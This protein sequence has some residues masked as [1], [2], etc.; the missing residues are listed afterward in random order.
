MTPTPTT[1]RNSK[2][3]KDANSPLVEYVK[4]S[5]FYTKMTN[6]VITAIT[7]HY[8]AGV[9]TV[10]GLG[11]TFQTRGGAANYGIGSDGRIGL[12]VDES[13]RA[14]TSGN[15]QNDQKAVTIEVSNSDTGGDWPVSDLV[16][17]KLVDLCEDVCRRN[18]IPYLNFT[19][20]TDGNMTMHAWFQSTGCP[21][22]YLGSKFPYIA[23]E[24]NRRLGS[25]FRSPDKPNKYDLG[26]VVQ[27]KDGAKY[28][29]GKQAPDWLKGKMLYIRE[30]YGKY[31]DISIYSGE[32]QPI[33]GR[34][35]EKYIV[36]L[37][38]PEEPEEKPVQKEAGNVIQLTEDAVYTTGKTIPAWV[39]N[40][41]LYLREWVNDNV[42]AF[43]I[44]QTGGITG[45]VER[46]YII[47]QPAPDAQE[48]E[49]IEPEENTPA[50][51][52][53][54]VEPSKVPYAVTVTIVEERNGFGRMENGGWIPLKN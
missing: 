34:V 17:E 50:E 21:G 24:V 53:P 7:P 15:Y 19:G 31:Y 52:A 39:R 49:V 46:K 54:A 14:H 37:E 38:D 20:D 41:T 2:Y 3:M 10:E 13:N 9:V 42:A 11:T 36:S 12:Y 25:D 32:G 16:L 45:Y 27:L 35:H 6:K 33:T 23:N 26:D 8:A 44:Y 43:S 5:P 18:G 1:G 51:N 48:P 29:D 28:F 40:S 4:Y 22:R 30:V 47:Q